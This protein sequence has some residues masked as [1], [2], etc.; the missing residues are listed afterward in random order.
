MTTKR[1]Q[2]F[3]EFERYKTRY[4]RFST[5]CMVGANHRVAALRK[6]VQ[7]SPVAAFLLLTFL[8]SWSIWGAARILLP[9]AG[10]GLRYTV[11]TAGLFAPT[12]A[13]LLLSGFLY[14]PDRRSM[15]GL[16]PVPPGLS[17]KRLPYRRL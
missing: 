1:E 13:A 15:R 8:I 6:W 11:H 4:R 9:G 7:S 10:P 14:G 17:G 2:F 3:S 16:A 12:M 5:E